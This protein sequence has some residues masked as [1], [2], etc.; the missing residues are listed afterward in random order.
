MKLFEG[1]HLHTPCKHTH[2]HTHTPCKHTHTHIVHTHMPLRNLLALLTPT[3]RGEREDKRGRRW[4]TK[5]RNPLSL[6]F[7]HTL[8][9]SSFLTHKFNREE[10]SL[11]LS[12]CISTIIFLASLYPLFHNLMFYLTLTLMLFLPPPLI[13]SLF[14]HPYFENNTFACVSVSPLSN[15]VVGNN[16]FS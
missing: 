15:V 1:M 2:T 3:L 12:L 7:S 14:Y 6:F 16:C 5:T 8:S 4:H 9:H 13:L 11:S 10:P